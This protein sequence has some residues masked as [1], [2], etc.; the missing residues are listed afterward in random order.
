MSKKILVTYASRLDATTGVAQAIGKTLT[1]C[2]AQVD[3]LPMN[4]VKDLDSYQAV[5]AVP[6]VERLG[7]QRPCNSLGRIK[8][9]SQRN[10]SRHF[11]CV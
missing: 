2:G 8:R 5:V 11:W 7:C 1:E 4:E 3:V 10:P 9:L 6:F